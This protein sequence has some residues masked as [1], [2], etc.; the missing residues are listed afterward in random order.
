RPAAADGPPPL[1]AYCQLGVNGIS[2]PKLRRHAI[3]ATGLL[4][5]CMLFGG[6]RVVLPGIEEGQRAVVLRQMDLGAVAVGTGLV[7]PLA[8]AQRAFD[9]DP[10]ALHQVFLGDLAKAFAVKITTRCHSV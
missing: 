1:S 2:S 7:L 10:C 9:E 8:G 4:T 6:A 3:V 5:R